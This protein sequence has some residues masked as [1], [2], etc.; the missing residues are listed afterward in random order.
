MDRGITCTALSF[1]SHTLHRWTVG[2]PYA[3]EQLNGAWEMLT[4]RGQSGLGGHK[5]HK[6]LYTLCGTEKNISDVSWQ[7]IKPEI[8]Y[9]ALSRKP[10]A[11]AF[12][13]TLS[14]R[15]YIRG[16]PG[17]GHGEG[18]RGTWRGGGERQFGGAEGPSVE[19]GRRVHHL[20]QL[21]SVWQP[22]VRVVSGVQLT[23][24]RPSAADRL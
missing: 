23:T 24:S 9:Q 19:E 3:E 15:R 8:G 20:R 1:R 21:H 6:G 14:L 22:G 12:A 18:R 10:E 16:G 11:F 4:N 5:G 17:R 2:R 7:Q 13:R